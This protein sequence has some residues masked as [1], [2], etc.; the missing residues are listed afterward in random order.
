M[1]QLHTKIRFA[2]T[3]SDTVAKTD[4]NIG[5]CL[6]CVHTQHALLDILRPYISDGISKL[7]FMPINAL[8]EACKYH[9]HI[10]L[11]KY[12]VDADNSGFVFWFTKR[13]ANIGKACE[14]LT[15]GLLAALYRWFKRILCTEWEDLWNQNKRQS[16]N[17]TLYF[18][19]D[20][21]TQ[22]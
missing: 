19:I 14:K 5:V 2:I 11:N 1:Q 7:P 4:L 21:R 3:T 22:R 12:V 17:K 13:S 8:R 16:L 10:A 18:Y 9:T 15:L 20:R 6:K